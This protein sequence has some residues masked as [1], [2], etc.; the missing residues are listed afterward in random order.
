MK[1]EKYI[2]LNTQKNYLIDIF[3]RINVCGILTADASITQIKA[4]VDNL[5]ETFIYYE[6]FHFKYYTQYCSLFYIE[7]I[8]FNKLNIIVDTLFDFVYFCI[9]KYFIKEI[10]LYFSSEPVSIARFLLR[11]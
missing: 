7:K 11:N 8:E 6:Y 5:Y 3:A 10:S 9:M 2:L 1:L 4:L